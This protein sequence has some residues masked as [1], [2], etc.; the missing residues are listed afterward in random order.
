MKIKKILLTGSSGKLG[1]AIANSGQFPPL[2]KPSR[3]MLDIT[4]PKTIREYFSENDFDAVIHCAALARMKECQE[5][6]EKAVQTN[7]IGTGNLVIEVLKKE[8]KLQEKIR[9]L[10]VSTDGVYPGIKGDY[11]ENDAASPYNKYGWTKLGAECAVKLLSNYCRIRT[12]FFDPDNI[13]FNKSATDVFSSKVP[14][15]YLVEAI[16]TILNHN[17]IGTINIGSERKSDYEIYKE[18]K[19]SLQPCRFKDVAEEAKIP[20]AKDSSMNSSIWKKIEKETK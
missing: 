18:F 9:F 12:A 19:L 1:K 20:L 6:P 15:N 4:N 13:R 8:K 14:I 17:F 16:A 11:S 7:L 5:D 3:D 2:L 10:H